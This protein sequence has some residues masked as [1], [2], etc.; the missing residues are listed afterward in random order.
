M[1]SKKRI[2][3]SILVALLL[4]T[5]VPVAM[6]GQITIDRIGGYYSGNGGEFNITGIGTSSYAAAAIVN[7]GFES[8]CLETDEYV[9]ITGKYYY[10][11]N[12]QAVAGGSN[13]N[14]GDPI[15]AGTAYLYYQ[16]AKGTLEGYNYIVSSGR[17][18]SARLLQEAIWFLE[19]E[20]SRPSNNP[21]VTAAISRFGTIEAAKANANGMFGV[22]VINLWKNSDKTGNAQDQL[23]LPE[24]GTLLL[25]GIGFLGLAAAGRARKQ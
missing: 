25:L 1:F 8:F 22:R 21:F 23:Y 18:N 15:S 11:F 5:M 4:L 16:F 24:P 20:I 17:T 13:T 2:N 9:T 10:T 19:D 14:S 6:G 12:N 7:G 3:I